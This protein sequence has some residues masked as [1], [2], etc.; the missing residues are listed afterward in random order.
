MRISNVRWILS[1]ACLLLCS[2]SASAGVSEADRWWT[3]VGS[4]GTLDEKSEGKVTFDGPLVQKGDTIVFK[5][6]RRLPQDEGSG[7]APQTDSAVIRYNVTAVD[8]L[9]GVDGIDMN[10]R[11]L[12]AGVGARVTARLM[13]VNIQNGDEALL[14]TFDSDNFG[15][16]S[17]YQTQHVCN[18]GRGMQFDF[19]KKV[20]Y[21]DATLTTSAIEP[22][23]AAGIAA[24]TLNATLC[25]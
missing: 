17:E 3:T 20:Y 6:A 15:L 7:G 14:L 13:E 10:V 12:A 22:S 23:S 11:Y 2:L 25:P 1:A 24:I 4:T 16:A 8:G 5:S 9:F 19:A 18:A 21:I